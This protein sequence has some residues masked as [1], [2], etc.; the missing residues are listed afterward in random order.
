MPPRAKSPAPAKRSANGPRYTEPRELRESRREEPDEAP[1]FTTPPDR[2]GLSEPVPVGKRLAALHFL[3]KSQANL[4]SAREELMQVP[5]WKD[6]C[7][8]DELITSAMTPLTR[9]RHA[10]S[11]LEKA[12]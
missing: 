4:T 5:G 3:E 6:G 7:P 10:L 2:E 11:A 9:L 8:A 12:G 1:T